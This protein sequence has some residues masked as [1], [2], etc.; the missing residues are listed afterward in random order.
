MSSG[1]G[2]LSHRELSGSHG[3]NYED[4]CVRDV[5]LGSLIE[6][7]RRFRCTYCLRRQ[8]HRADEFITYT[9]STFLYRLYRSYLKKIMF[10]I[11]IF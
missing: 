8:G 1:S 7:G 10:Y 9:A 3:G 6:S 11:I 2:I 4:D 5:A